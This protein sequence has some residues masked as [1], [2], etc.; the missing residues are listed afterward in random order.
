[1]DPETLAKIGKTLSETEIRKAASAFVGKI[2]QF[3]PKYSAVKI[4][5]KR[6]YHLARRERDFE[7]PKRQIEIFSLELLSFDFP[8]ARFLVRA[9]AGTYVRSLSRDI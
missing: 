8:K 6:A 7:L 1:M 3:P 2:E 4:D 5:G 9:S